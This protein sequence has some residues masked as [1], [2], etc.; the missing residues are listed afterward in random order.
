MRNRGY[1]L[2]SPAKQV[3]VIWACVVKGSDWVKKCI[4][5]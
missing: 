4:R 2:G 1:K 3:A 5:V